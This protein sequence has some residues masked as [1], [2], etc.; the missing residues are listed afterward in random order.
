M[1]RDRGQ[2][3]DRMQQAALTRRRQ[4]VGLVVIAGIILL[5]VLL[6]AP[7]HAIFPAGWWRF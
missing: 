3:V 6:R 7:A 1:D 5:V 4:A 2:G